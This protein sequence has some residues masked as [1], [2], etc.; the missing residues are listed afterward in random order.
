MHQHAASCRAALP[1]R[2]DRT[3]DD[4]RHREIEIGRL[5][6]DDGVVATQLQQAL[7]EPRSNALADMTTHGS[8][9]CKGDERNARILYEP[10]GQ[11]GSTIN[12]DLENRRQLVGLHHPVADVL[13]GE[14]GQRSLR[15]RLPDGS[16]AADGGQASIPR[17]DGHRE[18]E[19]RDDSNHSQRMPLLVHAVLRPLGVH[20][21]AIQHPRLPHGEVGDV[22]HLLNFAEPFRQDLAIL[23]RDQRPEVLLVT[24]QLFAQQANRLAPLRRRNAAP[25]GSGLNRGRHDSFVVSRT[26]RAAFAQSTR[27]RPDCVR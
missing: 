1:G 24:A 9:S 5:I 13:H 22:D 8:R 18:V 21:R 12:E 25:R 26:G 17:P 4:G 14:S 2:T 10:R 15:R 23:E 11:L 6:D 16:V 3:E 7:A 27:H 20:G 19:R